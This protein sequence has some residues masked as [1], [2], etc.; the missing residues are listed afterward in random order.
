[1]RPRVIIIVFL[2]MLVIGSLGYAIGIVLQA[3][4][5]FLASLNPAR[6]K[7]QSAPILV[8]PAHDIEFVDSDITLVWSSPNELSVNQI[9]ALRIWA[10]DLPYQE[11]WTIDSKVP[12]QQIIDSFSVDYGNYFWQVAI[13]NRDANGVYKSMG[14]DWSAV[15]VMRRLRRAS[16]PAEPYNE[17]SATA[18]QF[19][20]LGLDLTA[21]IDAVHLFIH[22]HSVTDEQ[23]SYAPDY[24][25]AVEL[26][27]DFSQGESSELPHL[28]CDGRSTAMIT[29]LRELGIESRLVF[30]YRSDPG[31]LSQHTVLEIFNPER[32]RWQVHDV[33]SDFYYVDSK[34]GDRVNAASILFGS[35]LD[36]LGCP[37][38]GGDCSAEV[39]AKSLPYFGAL[40]YGYTFDVWVNP[41]RF[42]LSARFVGQDDQNLAEFIGDGY[43]QRVTIQMDSWLELECC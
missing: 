13:L 28:Q 4:E 8:S 32:Q 15:S 7:V 18:Q 39:M 21:T 29:I 17:M 2:I 22:Q 35:H 43:P 26:M 14:S 40:R 30:L 36:L 38:S 10:N 16:I 1:M 27:Y 37:I 41:D 9:Y 24:S 31:W 19:Y 5:D 33:G 12:I 34:S 23:F 42:D 6:P 20:D 3:P 25:D 11:I